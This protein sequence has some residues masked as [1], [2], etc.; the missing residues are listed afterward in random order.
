MVLFG[1]NQKVAYF[2]AVSETE[3]CCLFSNNGESK[4]IFL[5]P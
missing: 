4:L 2:V 5:N 3:F 1:F